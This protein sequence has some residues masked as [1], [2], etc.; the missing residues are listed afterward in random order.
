VEGDGL[1]VVF[2]KVKGFVDKF[3][4]EEKGLIGDWIGVEV[5]GLFV[6]V[7]HFLEA[8]FIKWTYNL[9]DVSHLNFA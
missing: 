3:L 7:R 6:I 5:G 4:F 2:F 8:I 1:G 9:T